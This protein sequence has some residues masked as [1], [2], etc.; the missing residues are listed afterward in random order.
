MEF[1]FSNF[2][3]K[4]SL[5]FLTLLHHNPLM[6]QL[7]H[8]NSK[9]LWPAICALVLGGLAAYTALAWVLQVQSISVAPSL[10]P[11]SVQ[12]AAQSASPASTL[13]NV[14]SAYVAA[15]LGAP[16]AAGA[17]SGANAM[18][19]DHQWTLLGV[20]AG[21]SGQGSALLSV[22]GQPPKAYRPGQVVAPGWV[23]HS[24]GHRLARLAPAQQNTPTLTLELP[25]AEP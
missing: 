9:S 18:T 8:G 2:M 10:V 13:Q 1:G 22:D 16:L 17:P 12:V 14:Q 5:L 3:T 25:K 11:S 19:A 20:V 15:A 21:A 23:L 6:L 7:K 4:G 24:V